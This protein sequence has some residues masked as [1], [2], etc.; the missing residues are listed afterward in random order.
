MSEIRELQEYALEILL[1]VDQF[2]NE[3]QITYYLGEGSLLGAIRHHGF[4]PWDDDIDL[5]MPRT[6]YER[7]IALVQKQ[8]LPDGY[9]LDCFETNPNHWTIAAKVQ[10]VRQT[11]FVSYKVGKLGLHNGP[12]IDIFPLDQVPGD[13]AYVSRLDWKIARLRRILW[14]KLGYS[15]PQRRLKWHNAKGLGYF[16]ST[17]RL[18]KQ[19][20]NLMKTH[21]EDESCDYLVNFGS[22]YPAERQ[23][24]QAEV[25]GEPRLVEFEGRLL[26]VPAQAEVLLSRIYSD[27]MQLPPEEQRVPKHNFSVVEDGAA[28]I[29]K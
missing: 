7:F 6:E 1:A 14:N 24:V 22:L 3:N 28:K 13:L 29:L 27:Y 9:D 5:L 2:C 4:I 26:P 19:I 11:R 25:Y 12:S 16:V 15:K 21:A 20:T 17:R 10:M 18:Q 8:G 23:L